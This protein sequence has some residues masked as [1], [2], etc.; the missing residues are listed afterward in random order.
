MRPARDAR[1]L[2]W[3]IAGI[4][5]AASGVR[6]M[7]LREIYGRIHFAGSPPVLVGWSVFL[8]GLV[9]FAI[10]VYLVFRLWKRR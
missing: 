7:W 5:L 3:P 6:H 9:E 1:R 8:I 10:G 2:G 4:I